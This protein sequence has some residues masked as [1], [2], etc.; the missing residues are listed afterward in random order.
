LSLNVEEYLER[1]E[2]MLALVRTA[3]GKSSFAE[4]LAFT[5]ASGRRAQ[6]KLEL[7]A[8]VL[9]I[10]LEDLLHLRFGSTADLVNEDI[11]AELQKIA[12][13]IPFGWF[14]KACARL[15]DLEEF[16]RRNIQ[17]QL[18]LEALALELRAGA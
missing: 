5:E 13:T 6:E 14:E 7:Q 11:R 4:L 10:L 3:L 18:A 9:T 17:K 1:R 8:E 12:A 15:I 2:G 16:R